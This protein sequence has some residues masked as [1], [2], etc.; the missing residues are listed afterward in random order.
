M[1]NLDPRTINWK[2][3]RTRD[4]RRYP[5]YLREFESFDAAI[6]PVVAELQPATFDEIADRVDWEPAYALPYWLLSAQWRSLIEQRDP[7]ERLPMT[8]VLGPRAAVRLAHAA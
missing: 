6:L 2:R 5:L 8:Y 7:T 1:S 3:P 4:G